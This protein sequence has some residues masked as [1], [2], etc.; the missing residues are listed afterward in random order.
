MNT[1]RITAI[2]TENARSRTQDRAC[3][4]LLPVRA[5]AEVIVGGGTDGSGI[6]DWFS[7]M[8]CYDIIDGL[9]AGSVAFGRGSRSSGLKRNDGGARRLDALKDTVEVRFLYGLGQYVA[10]IAFEI[11]GELG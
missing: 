9:R 3:Q 5:G 8:A 10:P 6:G 1:I 11:V 7:C 2:S 4:R